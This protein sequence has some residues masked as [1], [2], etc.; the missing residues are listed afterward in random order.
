MNVSWIKKI[1]R[2]ALDE[3]AAFDDVTTQ[4]LVSKNTKAQAILLAKEDLIL[5]GMPVVE[6]VFKM[7]D[8]R[9]KIHSYFKEGNRVRRGKTIA[10]ISGHARVLL[11]G[12]RVALNF[13]QHLSGIAT[14]TRSFVDKVKGTKAKILDTRKTM[15]GLRLLERYAV[16]VGGGFNHRF[17]LKSVAM[18]KD[19]HLAVVG[20]ITKAWERLLSLA[21]KIPVILEVKNFRELQA[22]LD[23]GAPYLQL[24]NMSIPQ[25]KKAVET[26]RRRGARLCAPTLEATGGVRLEN[27]RAIAKTGVDFISAGAITHSVRAVDISLEI[28]KQSR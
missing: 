20:S 6:V 17:D 18:V 10:K 23:C 28:I 5:C 14:L 7:L 16:C 3:D 27:V 12:E 22:A 8:P 15:P 11:S 1:V 21:K 4:T 26:V 9:V 2:A 19:N 13:L 25:L 24:D